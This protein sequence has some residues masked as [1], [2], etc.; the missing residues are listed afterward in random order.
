M[1][2]LPLIII[3]L[4]LVVIFLLHVAV[5]FEFINRLENLSYDLRLK[6]T[7]PNTQDE[8]IFIIDID[9]KSLAGVGRWPWSRNQIALMLDNLFDYYQVAVVGFDIVFAERDE[10]SG[11]KV[12]E[13]LGGQNLKNDTM[14]QKM[15]PELRTRLDY[16][17]LF[18]EKIKGRKVVLGYGFSNDSGRVA[19]KLPPPVFT[20]NTLKA[21]NYFIERTGYTSNLPEL[22]DNAHNAGHFNTYIDIDGVSRRVPI[23]QE[24]KKDYYDAL[25]VA[26]VR[27]FLGDTPLPLKTGFGKGTTKLEWL[28]IDD[29]KI[30][31]D[32][33]ATALIPYRGPEGSFKYISA[34]DILQKKI[35]KDELQG[36]IILIGSTATGLSD[37]RSTPVAPV[38]PGVEIHANMI[39]GILDQKIKKK[40]AYAMGAE[41]LILLSTGLVLSLLL[42]LISPLKSTLVSLLTLA[43]AIGINMWAWKNNLVLPLAASVVMIPLIYIFNMSYGFF[44]ETKAKRKI[45]GLFGQ[46]VP[47]D[48]VAQMSRNP[49]KFS[50]EGESRELTVLFADVRNF[51]S[52]SE[53]LS[54]KELSKLMNEYM[55]PMTSIIQKYMGTIDKYI[56]DA[57]MAFWGAPL[58]DLSHARNGILAGLE[59]QQAIALLRPQFIERGWPAI[60]IGVGINSGI[61]RVGNMGSQFRIAYTVM[62]DAV[63]LGSRLEGITKE[64]GIGIIVGEATRNSV[65]DIVFRELDLV[66]VK[67]K[68]QPVA[69][70]EPIG[71]QG[72]LDKS[73]LDEVSLF[74]KSLKHYRAMEWDA[75]E[76]SLS[77]LQRL[78]PQSRLFNL[79]LERIAHFRAD[80]PAEGWDGVFQFKTK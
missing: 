27:S 17:N 72:Q 40:P 10:S 69:I 48:L 57:I 24:Y 51:T 29:F 33:K 58:Q 7:M 22:Q 37:L 5:P 68:N 16:N 54:P 6:L 47:R 4:F 8:R 44:I 13:K 61:M 56:G 52:I 14:Y 55:S 49:E 30:P 12:L 18:A 42:P 41:L 25:C 34:I 75:A 78:Y 53:S 74:E 20:A 1:K 62:G 70:Y 67:G 59:M 73:L 3:N 63:N 66:R 9:E 36:G 79:Y 32:E 77:G 80:P 71:L 23:L 11:L 43:C 64:Y 15:L 21:G 31:I 19:G 39:A 45:T 2:K 76:Q 35:R 28:G 50:M 60:H 46:Y 26:M 38:Y 65:T